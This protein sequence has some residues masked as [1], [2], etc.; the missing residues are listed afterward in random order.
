VAG[1][2]LR[3]ALPIAAARVPTP[4]L[5]QRW[6]GD[7]PDRGL[8]VKLAPGAD[9]VGLEW[10]AA[11]GPHV[12]LRLLAADG[13]WSAWTSAAGCCGDGSSP[14]QAGARLVGSP[15]WTAGAIALGLRATSALSGVRLH[16][17]DVSGGVGARRALARGA[18][19]P[20]ALPAASPAALPGQPP[21]IARRA[22]AR[23]MARPRLAPAYGAVRMAFVHH[24]QSPNGYLA[25]EVP[26][27]LLAIFLYHRDV[28]GWNDIGYNFVIDAFG[29]IFEARAGGVDEPVVGAQAG[30]FNLVSTG[31]AVLGSFSSEAPPRPAG[32]ALRALL[33]W[34]LSLHGVPAPG[35]AVVT[36]NA[37]GAIYSRFPAGARVSL[38]HIAGHRDGDSTDCPGDALYARLP[39]LRAAVRSRAPDPARATLALSIAAATPRAP[40]PPASAPGAVPQAAPGPPPA[41]QSPE[42]AAQ[43]PFTL[44]G[45]LT[46]LD[47]A[48]IADAAIA[49]QV[50]S[51]SARGQVVHERAVA[52]VTTDAAGA[53]S[54]SGSAAAPARGKR[55]WLRA[56]Y[57]GRAAAAPAAAVS[58]PL[59]VPAAVVTA[60]AGSP[61][62]AASPPPSA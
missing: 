17:V 26:A 5:S 44:S 50:R 61:K 48:P 35:R 38:P 9:L 29:R 28:R 23:G 49:L 4:R 21:I 36:V 41:G 22:W 55:L 10:P 34:K 30:G 37:A 39:A 14:A 13:R 54:L 58:D 25:S 45:T 52:E 27:M 20:G 56:L 19:S 7:V 3:P 46:L 16:L 1:A 24:T 57:R 43:T 42:V 60:L 11:A 59:A 40:L 12:Q 53:W 8:T 33:A 2:L 18:L 51:V 31:V 32:D 6:L 47:G 15:V 62:R